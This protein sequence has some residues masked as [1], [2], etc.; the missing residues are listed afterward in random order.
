MK[1]IY[2]KHYV[3]HWK[4]DGQG[5]SFSAHTSSRLENENEYTI[6]TTNHI[7]SFFTG[8]IEREK[9]KE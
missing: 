3:M 8:S 1:H 7:R 4:N 5:E 6:Y 2:L 9:Q